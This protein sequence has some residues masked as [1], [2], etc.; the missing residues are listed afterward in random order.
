MRRKRWSDVR[1]SELRG[2]IGRGCALVLILWATAACNGDG[3][4]SG[5]TLSVGFGLK[6]LEFT[7]TSVAD[8]DYY[9]LMESLDSGASFSQRGG[10]I[11]AGTTSLTIDIAVHRH[12]WANARYQLEACNTSGCTASNTVTTL[13]G[14][15]QAIGYMKASNTEAADGFSG[16]VAVSG[17][18]DTVVVGATGEDSSATGIDGTTG[19]NG[20]LNAGAVYVYARDGAGVWTQQAYVKAANTE[21]ADG[22]GG[23]VA[24]S[25]DGDTMVVGAT[26]EDSSA[27][28]IDGPAGNNGALNAG[29]VYVYTRDTLD[30]WT[31]QAYVKA[32]NT[33]TEDGFGRA[34][35]VSGDGDTVVVGATGEDSS[36][37]GIDGT[38]G[39]NNAIDSGA[40]YVYAR[41]GA[42]VWTQ[43]AYV[44]AANTE[45]ADG[46]GGAVAV[47]GDGDT[48]VV[49]A[50][51][52][53]SSAT[54]IDGA[55]GNNGALNA[56]AVYVYTR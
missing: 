44:K 55:A 31:Q 52:E 6:Q 18:G 41:D 42:G 37:T 8:A 16:A 32:S 34:V 38:E 9:R 30:V 14:L 50:T 13:S 27:T 4:G 40:V 2:L 29:A 36:A 20:A 11:A 51:G 3:T 1:V 24:V 17:D 49:G 48:V 45:A 15:L 47:S 39:D 7:W 19:N 35:A 25:G 5:L 21:A 10:Q 54:G 22:F 26:G 56:G 33:E 43:Q 53:D 23:A 46:F 28:G 12:D